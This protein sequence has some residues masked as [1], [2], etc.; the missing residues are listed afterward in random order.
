MLRATLKSLLAR[1]LR[2]LMSAVAIILGVGFVAGS[3]IFTDTLKSTFDSIMTGTVGDVHVRPEGASSE[4]GPTSATVPGSE[5]EAI[6]ALPGV[7]RADGN[8]SNVGTFVIGK[9]GK[10][11]GGTGAPGIAVNYHDAPSA[12]GD[13]IVTITSGRAPEKAGEVV[14]DEMTTKR[15]E[16]F[17]GDTVTMVSSGEEPTI[18]AKLVGI[19]TFGGGGMAGASLA[20]FDTP[21]AQKY[22]LDGKDAYNDI[23]VTA[24]DGTSQVQLRDEIAKTL[25]KD[26]EAVTG[27]DLA[28]EAASQ[29]NQALSFIN[30]FLL[31]FGAVAL[32][33]GSFLIIN[34]FSILV[35]QRS[36]EL[37]LFRAIGAQRRQVVRSVIVEAVVV[38]LIGSTIGLV[39]G[40]LLAQ[41]IKLLFGQ[42]GLDLAGSGLG[43][44]VRTV[45]VAYVVGLTVTVLAAYLPARRAGQVPPVAAMRDE[46]VET[47]GSMKGRVAVGAV[48]VGVGAVALAVG[49]FTE[50]EKALWFV[51]LGIFGVVLGVAMVSPL[52]GRPFIAGI[53]LLYR[54]L[55][56]T[57]GR[58][59]EQNAVRN[60][61]RTA[62]TASALMI[63]LTLVS[64]MAVLGSSAS[65]SI[66]KQVKEQFLADFV[67]SNAVG[68][69]FSTKVTE[70]IADVPGVAA[71]S[72]MRYAPA[73][74]EGGRFYVSAIDPTSFAEVTQVEMLEGEVADLTAQGVLVPEDHRTGRKIGDTLTVEMA[75]KEH[76]M[77]V[78]GFYQ[79][80]P[81]LSGFLFSLDGFEEMG[82]RPADNLVYVVAEPGASTPALRS[83]LEDA[84]VDL[85]TVTLK[86]QADYAEEVRGQVNQLLYIIYALL[87]LAIVIAILGII[88]TLALSVM[89]RTREIGLL[90]AVGLTRMQLRRM[91]WLES[92]V[93]ALLGAVL[94]VGLGVAFGIALQRSLVEDGIDVLA[95]PWG[96]VVGALVAAAVVGVLAALWPAER[97]ARLDVLRAIT[98]E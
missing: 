22:F 16:Y 36:R 91:I 49:L 95:I 85:P 74:I 3:L 54:R 10:V 88:N 82:I 58:M 77:R 80:T 43:L 97:A 64:L 37:A 31:I 60:P 50:V 35:A 94:G 63:G 78:D 13:P 52:A 53:G 84:I 32:F 86:D 29:V 45:V 19:M 7:A 24:E 11:V 67:I 56:G 61:R 14:L 71:A 5:L 46:A 89:E 92:V 23:Q 41:L 4:M 20:A 79:T 12:A 51:G 96:L 81:S 62:A 15:A 2:L 9:N 65:S 42:L 26:Q 18:Q 87:G 33:V 66:D 59:A 57:V 83:G 68:A 38:G 25:P 39:V 90:R 47:D 75:G 21:T 48:L 76:E 30:T 93:I 98:T 17:L 1:K 28:D 55:F 34:T 6:R 8:I 72:P 70:E 69:P 73:T 40:Y 44:S 27:D